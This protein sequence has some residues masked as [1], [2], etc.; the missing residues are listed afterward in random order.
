MSQ[1]ILVVD[2][3][4]FDR[5][6]LIHVLSSV[7]NYVLIEASNG[8]QCL[9]I[10]NSQAVDLVLLDIVMP[11]TGGDDILLQVRKCFNAVE[12]P[13]IMVTGNSD[14]SEV[15][16]C[17]QRGANDY[18]TKPLNFEVARSRIATQLRLAELSGEMSKLREMAALDALITTYNHEINNPLA[19]AI[20]RLNAQSDERLKKALWRISDVVK[21]IREV[22]EKKETEYGSYAGNSKMIVLNK[23]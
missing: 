4:D 13:I 18:I 20:G 5:K 23:K 3:S 6:L 7:E 2:D 8:D 14:T 17:L 19:I 21:K 22:T 11:G 9:E 16:N 10:L 1:K 15:V 12:L